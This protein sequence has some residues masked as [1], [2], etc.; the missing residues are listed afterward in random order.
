MK[1]KQCLTV[2][3]CASL[4]LLAGCQSL[5]KIS[6]PDV[7]FIG[8]KTQTESGTVTTE[9]EVKPES[10]IA[11]IPTGEIT[12]PAVTSVV[13]P[14]VSNMAAPD[15]LT[16]ADAP[17]KRSNWK[18]LPSWQDVDLKT[19]L[20]AFVT[21]CARLKKRS[22][23]QKV[24][25]EAASLQRENSTV[26]R[27]F[28]ENNFTPYQLFNDDGSADGLVT[29]YY[30]ARLRGSRVRTERFKYPIYGMPNDLLTIDLG[31]SYSELKELRLR[32]RVEGNKVV[33]YYTRGEID[34]GKANLDSKILFWTDN[35][36]ELFFL[37]VQGS[38]RL[39]MPDGSLIKLGFAEHNGLP[40][41]SIGKKL[42]EMGELKASEAS[43]QGIKR[44]AERNPDRL[45]PLLASNPRYVFFRELGDDT[46][47]PIGALGVPLTDEHS[48][49]VD[50]H[51][52]PLGAPV[53]LATTYPNTDKPL[54]RLMAAQDVGG[55]IKG[56]VR[57]DF[58][59]GFGDEAAKQAGKMKQKG[60]I[61]VLF[62][63]AVVQS[64]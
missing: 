3:W 36:V 30:E 61:W 39:E 26:I 2:G 32:G 5:S 41:V 16:P 4:L 64:K 57:A 29:G 38:G 55:A 24:C 33:S 31:S 7:P 35:I 59:W 19:S 56:R 60:K 12:K 27:Q 50:K 23:W 51:S 8:K 63:N 10:I 48:I 53:F 25:V 21:G 17:Y 15:I 14:S 37:Q 20:T 45:Y 28:F 9:I 42:I 34:A 46:V 13:T 49:A 47:N 52:I 11:P 54:N 58:F 22:E 40:Y 6:L 1:Y 18:Q 62:P 44:W 43:M